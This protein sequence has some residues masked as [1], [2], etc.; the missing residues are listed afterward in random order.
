VLGVRLARRLAGRLLLAQ[1]RKFGVEKGESDALGCASFRRMSGYGAGR[2]STRSG[3]IR[4]ASVA[5]G[6]IRTWESSLAM[7]SSAGRATI[8]ALQ[9]PALGVS[10]IVGRVTH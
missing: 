10:R 8:S 4:Y 9:L 1:P 3:R 2:C 7:P 5:L 6:I